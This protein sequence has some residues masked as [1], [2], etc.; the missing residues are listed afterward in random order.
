MSRIPEHNYEDPLARIWLTA[1]S[2]I[3]FR[4]RRSSDVYA[5]TDGK[6]TLTIGS[7]NT[8]DSDDSLAQMIFHEL[9]HSLVEGL[10]SLDREDW[11]L[12]N[13]DDKDQSREYACLRLQAALTAPR[14]LRWFF[15][16][17]TEHRPYYDALPIDP[18][19]PSTDPI[20]IAARRGAVNAGRNPWSPHLT[21][22]LEAT[23]YIATIV[24]RYG[25]APTASL[26]SRVKEKYPF[27]EAGFPIG[28]GER[29]RET[30]G[31]CA[32]QHLDAQQKPR[33]RQAA[34]RISSQSPSCE[35]WE[36][37]LDCQDCGACCREAYGAVEISARDP[38]VKKR[39]ELVVLRADGRREL[40]RKGDR[41]AHLE[42]GQTAGERF[43]CVI[44]DDRPRTCREFTLGSE[45]CMTARRRVGLSR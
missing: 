11:G 30:C 12:S 10:A 36:P 14:G 26:W 27:H 16:P 2:R 13:Y 32:W 23:A 4:V 22:A 28:M 3:G 40:A 29:A 41:C 34:R 7:R 25:D 35:R 8:L 17:T 38:V 24:D 15:A 1:A 45:H 37:A 19:P 9:C 5:S 6:G 39:P 43:N 33:C 42:G 18:L 21:H 31:S 44:Y 20:V